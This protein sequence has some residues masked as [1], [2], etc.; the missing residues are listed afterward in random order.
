MLV[1]TYVKRQRMEAPL[2]HVTDPVPPPGVVLIPW[3]VDLLD[4][5]AEVKWLSF[6]DTVDA[7]I[8]PNLGQLDGCLQL[9]RAIA[10]HSG[11]V[12]GATWLARGPDGCCGCIQGV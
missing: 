7:A 2:R 11:F 6:R 10:G 8:F 3:D 1:R 5:H 12:P 4:A 9:M